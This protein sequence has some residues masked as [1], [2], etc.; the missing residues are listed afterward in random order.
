MWRLHAFEM[1]EAG[2]RNGTHIVSN[3]LCSQVLWLLIKSIRIVVVCVDSLRC[4]VTGQ[5]SS[6][7]CLKMTYALRQVIRT[8]L[9]WS[10][11]QWVMIISYRRFGTI[12]WPSLPPLKM[13]QIGCPETSVRNYNYSLCI[14]P[15]ERSS[16]LQRGGSLEFV[17]YFFLP[18]KFLSLTNAP[19]IKHIKC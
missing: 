9:F 1:S 4:V 2:G 14:R 18:S 7:D 12:Y 17:W 8:A 3:T 5:Q 13:W 6:A 19:F 10:I 11:T 16:H 15:E